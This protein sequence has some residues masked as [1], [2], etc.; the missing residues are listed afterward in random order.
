M[1]T[2]HYLRF[3]KALVLA[4]AL[5]ACSSGAADGPAPSPAETA[6]TTTAPPSA[7]APTANEELADAGTAHDGGVDADLPFSS[8]PIVPPELPLELA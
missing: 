5:P 2:P 8:G 1:S 6:D 3:V 7:P 4:A